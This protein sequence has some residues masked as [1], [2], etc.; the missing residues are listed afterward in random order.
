MLWS[1]PLRCWRQD[2]AWPNSYV[3][4]LFGHS[5]YRGPVIVRR[6]IPLFTAGTIYEV[7]NRKRGEPVSYA[8]SNDFSMNKRLS[9]SKDNSD[10][11][12]K[13]KRLSSVY[14][15]YL[16]EPRDGTL[17]APTLSMGSQLHPLKPDQPGIKHTS[18]PSS[19]WPPLLQ[20]ET[21]RTVPDSAENKTSLLYA[22]DLVSSSGIYKHKLI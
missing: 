5:W 1:S 19:P 4:L 22:I 6:K 9:R 12:M 15:N 2:F 11:V 3:F 20:T 16:L 17:S 10:N 13:L 8:K 18:E 14:N 7:R 21:L